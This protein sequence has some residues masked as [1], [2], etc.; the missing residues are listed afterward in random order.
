MP[1]LLTSFIHTSAVINHK[2][3]VE[4]KAHICACSY[5]IRIVKSGTTVFGIP[6]KTL[7]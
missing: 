5:V 2:V 3:I 6:A 4:D 1:N 7:I